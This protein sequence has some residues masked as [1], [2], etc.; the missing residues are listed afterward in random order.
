MHA[1]A[2]PTIEHV[3]QLVH[4]TGQVGSHVDEGVPRLGAGQGRVVTGVAVTEAVLDSALQQVRVGP[5]PM[6]HRD[7]V[8]GGDGLLH[9]VASDKGRPTDDEQ[10]H[11][12]TIR[13]DPGGPGRT[14]RWSALSA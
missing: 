3:G 12:R 13:P 4:V 9:Q 14:R 6:E 11:P 7:L 10:P 8:T 1:M 2:G 5:T